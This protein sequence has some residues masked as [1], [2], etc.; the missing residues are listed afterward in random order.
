MIID[1]GVAYED[2]S[3]KWHIIKYNLSNANISAQS[4]VCSKRVFI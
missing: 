4:I 3:D 1:V 2:S